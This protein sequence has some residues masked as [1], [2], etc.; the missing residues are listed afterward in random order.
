MLLRERTLVP[1]A[2]LPSLQGAV[3]VATPVLTVETVEMLDALP[4]ELPSLTSAFSR[5]RALF[6]AMT[7]GVA[8]VVALPVMAA[9][10]A[11]DAEII[12]LAGQIKQLCIECDRLSDQRATIDDRVMTEGPRRPEPPPKP[13]SRTNIINRDTAT[14]RVMVVSFQLDPDPAEMKWERARDAAKQAF[15]RDRIAMQ[16]RLGLPEVCGRLDR[17]WMRLQQSAADLAEMETRTSTGLAAKAAALMSIDSVGGIDD[18]G[19]DLALSI[20][21]DAVRLCGMGGARV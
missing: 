2:D 12:D 17:N 5:R 20:A 9:P 8:S 11:A 3:P 7:A 19:V 14:E 10:V 21:T 13:P 1:A 16:Q 6:G 15:D 4:P 18:C